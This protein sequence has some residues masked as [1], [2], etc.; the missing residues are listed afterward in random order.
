MNCTNL[1]EVRLAANNLGGDIYTLNFSTLSQLSKL[2]LFG[3]NFI[4]NLPTGLYSC[5][6]LQAIRLRDNNL[7]GQIHPEILSLK[8][9][10]FL[11]L[12]EIR[13][14][15][16]AGA[17]KILMRCKTLRTLCLSGSFISGAN[18]DDNGMVDHDGFQNLRV[19]GLSRCGITGPIP[20]W[21]SKLNNLQIL[22]LDSNR[23]MGSIPSWLGT[24]PRLF[25][26]RLHNNLISG[27]YP[28][29]LCRLPSLVYQLPE[30][31]VDDHYEFE[32]PAIST[33]RENPWPSFLQHVVSFLPPMIDVSNNN[34][35]G[36]IPTEI[37][38]LMLLHTLNLSSN[39]FSGNIPTQISNLLEFR[40]NI[41]REERREKS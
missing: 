23:I 2:D 12:A 21:L 10:S 37:G 13:L 32:F 22:T 1:I 24:L 5:R 33:V 28:K 8:S 26:M 38:Q 3:N 6:S 35:N 11:S 34:M 7:Q 4:G 31:Q 29:K 39:N 17:I 41:Q 36:S 20:I 40:K 25:H 16:L 19:L 9:L 30:S 18:L 27:E 14:T 15:N